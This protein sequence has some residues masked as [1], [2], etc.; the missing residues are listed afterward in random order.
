MHGAASLP[1]G[2]ASVSCGVTVTLLSGGLGACAQP[3]LTHTYLELTLWLLP[4][5]TR[6]PGSYC[7]SPTLLLS[8]VPCPSETINP[9]IETCEGEAVV[10]SS[11][12]SSHGRKWRGGGRGGELLG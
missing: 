8:S 3:L 12:I 6:S 5:V 1:P 2:T 7:G 10:G 4:W 11:L 9:G